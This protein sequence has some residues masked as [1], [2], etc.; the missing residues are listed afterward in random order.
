MNIFSF[1]ELSLTLMDRSNSL[2]KK[3]KASCKYRI[4]QRNYPVEHEKKLE[5][6][7]DST[8]SIPEML[9]KIDEYLITNNLPR[10]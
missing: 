2:E 4:K 6:I 7:I 5:I 9:S 10:Y 3:G 1:I 8:H